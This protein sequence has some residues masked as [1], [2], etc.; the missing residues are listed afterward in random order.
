[1]SMRIRT[2]MAPAADAGPMGGAG[3]IV[4]ADETEISFSRKTKKTAARQSKTNRKRFVAL[5]ER[6]GRVRSK[7]PHGRRRLD[8]QAGRKGRQREP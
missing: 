7:V 4:E 5:V 1:M 2:A 6:G 3:M 8:C